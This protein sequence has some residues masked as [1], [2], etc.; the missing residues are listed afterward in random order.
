MDKATGKK[1]TLVSKTDKTKGLD[2]KESSSRKKPELVQN[3]AEGKNPTNEDIWKQYKRRVS[4]RFDKKAGGDE[5]TLKKKPEFMKTLPH[6]AEMAVKRGTHESVEAFYLQYIK[7]DYA[8]KQASIDQTKAKYTQ[9]ASAIVSGWD[10]WGAFAKYHTIGRKEGNFVTSL[11]EDLK[12]CTKDSGKAFKKSNKSEEGRASFK[13]KVTVAE[14]KGLTSKKYDSGMFMYKY[15]PKLIENANN[16]GYLLTPNGKMEGAN[17]LNIPGMMTWGGAD[18]SK[19]ESELVVPAIDV[20]SFDYKKVIQT[21]KSSFSFMVSNPNCIV[22]YKAKNKKSG[23]VET[24][25]N[26]KLSGALTIITL[27]ANFDSDT[28]INTAP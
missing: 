6:Y 8:Y 1:S 7:G 21:L 9:G 24:Y 2:D 12:L 11:K 14:T 22:N 4:Y 17:A 5:E 26:V 10:V 13:D 16:E 15:S 25:N 3:A 19:S 27:D 20:S 18:D 28:L 23:K